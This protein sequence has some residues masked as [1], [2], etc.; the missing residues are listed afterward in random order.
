MRRANVTADLLTI[1]ME[2]A[3][4]GVAVMGALMEEDPTLTESVDV[5]AEAQLTHASTLRVKTK[6]FATQKPM[7]I[8]YI[9]TLRP[10]FKPQQSS[11][12]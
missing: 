1:V 7:S 12:I 9:I 5:A 3:T 11:T 8:E 6:K 4:T 10:W 2:V